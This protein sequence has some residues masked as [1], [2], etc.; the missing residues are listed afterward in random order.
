MIKGL[1]Y[2]AVGASALSVGVFSSCSG[3]VKKMTKTLTEVTIE[4][5]EGIAEAVDENGE[6]IGEKT[7]DAAGKVALGVG[8][9]LDRQLD[10]HAEK[11]A[12]VMGRTLVQ[13]VEGLDKGLT[14]EYY[15]PIAY[16][17]DICS[18]VS[19][20]YFGK[21]DSKA[22]VDAYFIVLDAGTYECKIEFEGADGNIFLSRDSEIE[23][24]EAVRKYSRV[25]FAL[26]PDEETAFAGL[27]EAKVTVKKK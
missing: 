1:F 25:S 15:T 23:N 26:S 9:S 12:S 24:P 20:D 2:I 3:C 17:Y 4:A 7:T 14:D 16:T 21:I 13:T 22:V 19:L 10:E 8:R 6:R 5:V 18:G 27:T 11:V